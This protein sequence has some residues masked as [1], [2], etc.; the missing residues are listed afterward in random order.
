MNVVPIEID[1]TIEVPRG[2]FVKRGSSGHVDFISPLPCPYNYGAA[3]RFIGLEG[4]LLDAILLGPRKPFGSRWRT[5]AWGAITLVDRD[6]ADDKL[7]CCDRPVTN[8]EKQGLL[9]FFRF[10]ARCKALLNWWRHRSGRNA[11]GG[12]HGVDFAMSR[13][14]PRPADWQGPPVTF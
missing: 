3:D 13:A 10:Y 9:R 7:I 14:R 4:D 12:W 5:L 6:V 8:D 2:S 11:C 1:V